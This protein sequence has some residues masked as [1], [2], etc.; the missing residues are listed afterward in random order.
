M[1]LDHKH[2]H[3]ESAQD[4]GQRLPLASGTLS[5]DRFP[6]TQDVSGVWIRATFHREVERI[7]HQDGSDI[8]HGDVCQG[9]LSSIYHKEVGPPS[10]N[11]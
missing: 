3:A 1:R 8:F 10:E 9:S 11:G 5:I 4:L 6:E 2:F 7:S